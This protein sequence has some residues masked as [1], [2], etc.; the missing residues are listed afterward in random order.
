MKICKF[1]KKSKVYSKYI[2]T[3]YIIII[4]MQHNNNAYKLQFGASVTIFI[5]CYPAT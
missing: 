3:F 1:K 5:D 2:H 4:M